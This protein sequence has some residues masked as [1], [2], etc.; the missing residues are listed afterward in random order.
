M[1]EILNENFREKFSVYATEDTHVVGILTEPMQED[2]LEFLGNSD[3]RMYLSFIDREI[4][5][6]I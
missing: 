5:C 3:R 1:D 4:F 2:I 6:A